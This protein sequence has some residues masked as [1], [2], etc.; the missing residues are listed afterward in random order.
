MCSAELLSPSWQLAALGSG[1]SCCGGC[2]GAGFGCGGWRGLSVG[3]FKGQSGDR[4]W[5]R[6]GACAGA[7]GGVGGGQRAANAV[8]S[9]PP[10]A[11]AVPALPNGLGTRGVSARGSAGVVVVPS[12]I[13]WGSWGWCAWLPKMPGSGA[14]EGWEM[15]AVGL[16]AVPLTQHP[17]T[18][19]PWGRW[20][21]G[22]G[23]C[24][25]GAGYGPLGRQGYARGSSGSSPWMPRA[26]GSMCPSHAEPEPW[27]C[28]APAKCIGCL[29][30]W[31]E[32]PWERGSGGGSA[33]AGSP[34]V[35][36]LGRLPMPP[37]SWHFT[38]RW[39]CLSLVPGRALSL[40]PGSH[41]APVPGPGPSPHG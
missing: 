18:H 24:H 10:L 8:T 16:H 36:Q 29:R 11:W 21:V 19:S 35:P 12:S 39:L 28:C 3:T 31:C 27:H 25:A 1:A 20:A 14:G 26:C 5:Y 13:P 40:L 6:A 9:W 15:A 34:Q 38:L 32:H 41:L 7:N 22:M 17:V 30:A 2:R 23:P 4:L 33:L 37:A